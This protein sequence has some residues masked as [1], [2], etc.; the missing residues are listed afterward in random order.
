MRGSAR[1]DH[2]VLLGRLAENHVYRI[3]RQ[4]IEGSR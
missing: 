1:Y 2:W 3:D 4:D